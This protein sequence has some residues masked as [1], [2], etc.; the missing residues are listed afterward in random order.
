MSKH[1]LIFALL[2]VLSPLK[3]QNVEFWSNSLEYEDLQNLCDISASYESAIIYLPFGETSHN[4]E[5]L[6]IPP[7]VSLVGEGIENTIIENAKFLIDTSFKTGIGHEYF[8]ITG[9]YLKTDCHIEIRGC[10]QFRVDN[11]KIESI[12]SAAIEIKHSKNGLIDH[13]T[14]DATNYGVMVSNGVTDRY[15]A[16]YTAETISIIGNEDAICIEDCAFYNYH[17]AAVCHANA[18]MVLRFNTFNAGG[19]YPS[20][21]VVAHGPGYINAEDTTDLGSRLVECYNNSFYSPDTINNLTAITIGG[22]SGLIFKNEFFDWR[23]G[24][25]LSL[26]AHANLYDTINFPHDIWIWDNIHNKFNRWDSIA[27]VSSQMFEHS[28]LISEDHIRI[29]HE[30]FLRAPVSQIDGFEYEPYYYPHPYNEREITDSSPAATLF[31]LNQT[32]ET[33]C[34]PNPTDGQ[35]FFDINNFHQADLF[36]LQGIKLFSTSSPS[37]DIS[38]L[39]KGHYIFKIVDLKGGNHYQKLVLY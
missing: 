26:D 28:P 32:D 2:F 27:M 36:N 7:G 20:Y 25:I 6:S 1:I 31:S 21:A 3:S 34:Y 5:V 11:C 4:D 38:N 29:D 39:P 18:H 30:Y 15:P 10:D 24:I 16:D 22:G 37:I 8:Q 19:E 17:H 13:C 12:G 9:I 35:V 33:I 23:N 14:I